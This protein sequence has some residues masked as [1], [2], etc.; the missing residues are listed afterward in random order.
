MLWLDLRLPTWAGNTAQLLGGLA[1]PLM[2]LALGASLA[3][4]SATHVRLSAV[5]A[6]LRIVGGCAIGFGV[7]EFMGLEGPAYGVVVI[8]ATMPAAVFNYLFATKYGTAGQEVAGAVF[9]ST[10]LSIVAIPV[11]LAYLL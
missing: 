11:L 1:I 6:V 4:L 5:I 3:S 2:L 8:Q 7:A 10:L 9:S